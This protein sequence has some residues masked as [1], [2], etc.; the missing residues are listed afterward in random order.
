M[1]FESRAVKMPQMCA[2]SKVALAR[3]GNIWPF[4]EIFLFSVPLHMERNETEQGNETGEF[5]S[6]SLTRNSDPLFL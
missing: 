2:Q 6:L 4:L 3:V 1:W 5:R